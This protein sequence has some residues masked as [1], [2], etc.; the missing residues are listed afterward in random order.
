MHP[1]IKQRVVII[2][3]AGQVGTPLTQTLLEL[4]HEVVAL[5]RSRNGSG[6]EKL[7]EYEAQGAEIIE[8]ADM[9]DLQN[10]TSVLK[11]AD[12]LVC[13]SPASDT[14]INQYETVWLEAAVNAG[15]KRFVPTEFGCHTRSLDYGDGILFDH[16]KRMHEKIFESGIG[17]TFIYNGVIFD[18]CLP[19]LRFFKQITTFGKMDIPIYTHEITDI[20]RVAAYAITDEC[21]MNKCVQLDYNALTQTEMLSM[22][23]TNFPDYPFEYEHFTTEFITQARLIVSDEVTGKKGTET[24]QERWGI[25]NVIYVLDKLAGFTDET[26]RASQLYPDYQVSKTPAQA[27]AD[28]DFVFEK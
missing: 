25:N 20:G 27:L 2:G 26:L 13:A 9:L 7:D 11:G 1:F 21:T 12:T 18:Y 28:P 3:A 10:M 8:I 22:L 19:N 24:D 17:W 15:V 14:I 5:T 6:K 23:K 16:K 4:G